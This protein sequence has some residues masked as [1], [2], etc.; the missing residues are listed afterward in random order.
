MLD[1]SLVAVDGGKLLRAGEGDRYDGIMN[2]S[3]F[4]YDRLSFNR[5]IYVF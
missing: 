5:S 2:F 3:G 1:P 4:F